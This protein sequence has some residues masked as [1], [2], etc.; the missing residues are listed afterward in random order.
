LAGVPIRIVAINHDTSVG[1]IEKNYSRHIA[2]HSDAVAR[3]ALLDTTEPDN[4]KIAVL[5]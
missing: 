2:D 4:G 3:R 1:M 5:R